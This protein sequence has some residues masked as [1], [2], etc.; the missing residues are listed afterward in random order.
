M[1]HFDRFTATT[2]ASGDATV[3]S[4][5]FAGR[6]LAIAYEDTDI[7][8][9]G[10]FTFTDDVLGTA[11]LTVTD[12]GGTDAVWYPRVQVHDNTATGVT[13]DGTNEIYEP[14]IVVTRLK[15]VVAQG[16]NTTSGAFYVVWEA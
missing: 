14:P 13:Y 8:S 11:I 16:G 6:V 2:D 15:L 7:D 3:Y 1:I 12:G 10:D 5:P 4:R 9:G